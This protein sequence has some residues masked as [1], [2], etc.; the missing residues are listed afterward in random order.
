MGNGGSNS[1]LEKAVDGQLPEGE[2][3]FGLVNNGNT[4]YCNS[5]LQVFCSCSCKLQA[6]E[7]EDL[8]ATCSSPGSTTKSKVE[9]IFRNAKS[10]SGL[11][12]LSLTLKNW[13]LLIIFIHFHCNSPTENNVI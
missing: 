4:G 10:R 5:V 7:S 3:Y 6:A 13:Q 1:K 2:R 8:P 12:L 9:H 11:F